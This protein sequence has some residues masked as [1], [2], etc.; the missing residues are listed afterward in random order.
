MRNYYFFCPPKTAGKSI[1]EHFNLSNAHTTF[2]DIEYPRLKNF[3]NFQFK[4]ISKYYYR[5][6]RR[7]KTKLTIFSKESKNIYIG[8][9]RN[10]YT[11]SVSWFLDVKRNKFHQSYH[12]YNQKMNFFDFLFFNQ[13]ST[14]FRTQ[15]S[16]FLDWNSQ[17]KI[18]YL[19]RF[20][21]INNDFEKFI[22][23]E[24]FYLKKFDSKLIKTNINPFI[25]DFRRFL[26][27][28]SV[29]LINKLQKDDFS[30]F[31]YKKLT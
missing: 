22:K 17:Y 7:K 6:I 10:P 15:K 14:G 3:L 24:K 20:E 9:I 28:K 12:K 19:I 26:C 2:K 31:G 27:P 8:T 29:N 25:Y 30:Y 11:R 23:K 13:K 5:L 16:Y 1:C 18:D 4:E 21:N